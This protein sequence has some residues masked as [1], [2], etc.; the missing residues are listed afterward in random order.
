MA[1]RKKKYFILMDSFVEI[2]VPHCLDYD[3]I[4]EISNSTHK[5]INNLPNYLKLIIKIGIIIISFIS[6]IQR[7]RSINSLNFKERKYFVFNNWLIKNSPLEN[8]IVLLRT[9]CWISYF[10]L[11]KTQKELGYNP[12]KQIELAF[13]KRK[14]IFKIK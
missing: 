14:K 8:I 5:L 11:V 2:L 12:I 9:F 6:L 3:T 13:E 1:I 4:L 10:N 7:G